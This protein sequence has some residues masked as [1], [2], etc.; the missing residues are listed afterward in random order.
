MVG[1]GVNA[2]GALVGVHRTWLLADG[3]GKAPLDNPRLTDGF[4]AGAAVR[5]GDWRRGLLAVAEGIESALAGSLLLG[6]ILAWAALSDGGIERL[7]LPAVI[8]EIRIFVDRDANNAGESAARIAGRRWM[9]E[10]R[11][12]ALTI[13]DRVGADANDLWRERCHV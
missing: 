12:V 1:G 8:R 2:V 13:P 9:A 3:S 5:L 10:G 7:I 4:L 6:G 11:R